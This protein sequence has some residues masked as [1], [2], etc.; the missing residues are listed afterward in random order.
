MRTVAL[1]AL[2]NLRGEAHISETA[3]R[4]GEAPNTAPKLTRAFDLAFD[5]EW[6]AKLS[7]RSG[8]GVTGSG[9]GGSGGGGGGGGGGAAGLYVGRL[10]VTEMASHCDPDECAD[11]R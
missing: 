8:G 3:P 5:L 2:T 6:M 7:V 9:G 4:R 11:Y 1:R 10:R